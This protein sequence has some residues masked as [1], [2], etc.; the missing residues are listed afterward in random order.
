VDPQPA[1]PRLPSGAILPLP[2]GALRTRVAAVLA[3]ALALPATAS[4][5]D[6]Q[7]VYREY[8]RTGTIKPCRFSDKQLANAEKQTPPDVEQYAP[9]FLD[10]L[11]NARE[12]SGDCGKK[13]AAAAPA[14]A[15]TTPSRAPPTPSTPTPVPPTTTAAT[16]T[17]A[18]PPAPTV[19]AQPAV[20]GVP[21]PPVNAAKKE[22]KAPAA[23]WLLAVIGA[24]LLLSAV[25]AG[26]AWW[27]GWSAER[28]M[29]P[30]KASWDDF[31]GRMADAGVEFR[32]WL[33]MGQ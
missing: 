29:R 9:S 8:K 32:D 7:N 16:P 28:F 33:K 19:P 13:P 20:T 18:A 21:S 27:F 12:R 4:A 10:E 1:A 17:T 6:F 26:L 23:V 11:Q 5:N 31:G 2:F 22:D 25:F 15:Q 30:W 24:L 14:P 3:I